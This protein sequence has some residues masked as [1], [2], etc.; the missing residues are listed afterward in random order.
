MGGKYKGG[1]FYLT[2]PD[3]FP[4]IAVLQSKPV[5]TH[6][7]ERNFISLWSVLVGNIH[8]SKGFPRAGNGNSFFRQILGR[9]LVNLWVVP[10]RRAVTPNTRTRT[11]RRTD[12]FTVFLPPHHD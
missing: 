12:R 3:S 8:S 2:V 10:Y 5:K 1:L 11:R 4:P 7:R 6:T 9:L